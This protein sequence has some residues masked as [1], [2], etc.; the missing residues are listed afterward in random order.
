MVPV[1]HD[2]VEAVVAKTIR[3]TLN[4]LPPSLF[5]MTAE[6]VAARPSDGF[7]VEAAAFLEALEATAPDALTGCALWRAHEL[8]AHLGAGALEI[9][10]NLEACGEGRPVPATRGFEE[11]EAPY[12]AMEDAAL[13]AAL[14]RAIERVAEVLDTVLGAEPDAVVPW[15]GRQMV[16]GS[17][18]THLR[19]E[20]ALH[21]FDLVG[22]D[23]TSQSLLGQSELTDHAVTVLGRALLARGA[24]SA[25]SGFSAVIA[26]PGASDLAVVVDGDGPRLERSDA[27]LEPAVIGDPAARLLLLWGRQPGD[28]RRL[29]AP[30]GVEVLATLRSLLAGY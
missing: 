21:R 22:D 29:A 1:G 16:V 17:F 24:A 2:S 12:R 19:S 28:P 8:A 27:D 7:A 4:Y 5:A 10:L 25:P 9:A 6:P 14:P 20:L 13:R 26:A 15:T 23:E 3:V 18:V 30:G 11:R